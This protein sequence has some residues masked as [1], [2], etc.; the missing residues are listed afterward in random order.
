MIKY[1][2]SFLLR[3]HIFSFSH[4]VSF[5]TRYTI[6]LAAIPCNIEQFP[7]EPVLLLNHLSI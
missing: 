2:I 1:S 4:H 3:I 7:K 6:L 5:H